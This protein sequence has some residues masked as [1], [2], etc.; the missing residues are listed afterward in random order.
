MKNDIA[1]ESYVRYQIT[2]SLG[3]AEPVKSEWVYLCGDIDR[4]TGSVLGFIGSDPFVANDGR[5]DNFN[6]NMKRKNNQV[7]SFTSKLL[8]FK[9]LEDDTPVPDS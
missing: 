8:W 5:L 7:T 9:D 6:L 4:T 3:N 1:V 2:M